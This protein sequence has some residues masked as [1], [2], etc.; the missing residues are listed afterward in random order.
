MALDGRGDQV[1]PERGDVLGLGARSHRVDQPGHLL[2]DVAERQDGHHAVASGRDGLE[3]APGG[4]QQHGLRYRHALWVPRGARRAED[5]HRLGRIG[6]RALSQRGKRLGAGGIDEVVK[7]Q[8]RQRREARHRGG[9]KRGAAAQDDGRGLRKRRDPLHGVGC[10]ARVERHEDHVGARRRKQGCGK[11]GA[12]RALDHHAF[13]R[14]EGQRETGGGPLNGNA[15]LGIGERLLPR[16]GRAHA[17]QRP[18][19]VLCNRL[20]KQGRQ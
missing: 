6:R 9:L 17:Q 2:H 3:T 5:L 4:R 8:D 13:P 11:R 12:G 16:R 14:L 20:L 18:S 7:V 19:A 1:R 10:H 15:K